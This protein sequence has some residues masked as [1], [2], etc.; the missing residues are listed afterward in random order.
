MVASQDMLQ[1]CSLARALEDINSSKPDHI[2]GKQLTKKP[3]KSVTGR[4]LDGTITFFFALLSLPL[5]LALEVRLSPIV[6]RSEQGEL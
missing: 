6:S 3:D 2:E 4:G 1:E 5:L